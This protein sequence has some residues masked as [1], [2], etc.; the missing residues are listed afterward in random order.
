MPVEQGKHDM[1]DGSASR[2]TG[3]ESVLR[4][5]REAI[6]AVLIA[7]IH[8]YRYTLGLLIGGRC[9]FYPSCSHYA[10]QALERHGPVRGSWLALRRIGRCHPLNPGGID[11]VPPANPDTQSGMNA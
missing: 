3:H 9:R 1:N 8:V 4:A 5:V 6:S 2:S 11:E 10:E 7:L